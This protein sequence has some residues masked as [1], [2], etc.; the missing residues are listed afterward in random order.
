MT[1]NK[2]S[3]LSI[4][5]V[6]AIAVYCWFSYS[7]YKSFN[8]GFNNGFGCAT[9]DITNMY[10]GYIE[11]WKSQISAAFSKA[12]LDVFKTNPTPDVV[13]PHP[14]P[15]KCICGGSGWIQQGDGH[16]T[17]CPYHG[18]SKM[19]SVIKENNLIYKPLLILE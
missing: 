14:D 17:K 11:D 1:S 18:E 12:E 16:R 5:F 13:G 19:N 2:K 4:V 8:T 7:N 6:V 9:E 10:E 15:D 3:L